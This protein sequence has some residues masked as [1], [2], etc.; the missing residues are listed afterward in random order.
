LLVALLQNV[1]KR[2]ERALQHK[3]DAVADGP[4]DLMEH[5]A[6]D[7]P[8]RKTGKPSERPRKGRHRTAA[9]LPD[10]VDEQTTQTP[11]L[12]NGWAERFF[13]GVE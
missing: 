13:Y 7:E 8:E 2:D 1:Q 11:R 6:A 4:T 9:I 12:W 10:R 5:F 3:L